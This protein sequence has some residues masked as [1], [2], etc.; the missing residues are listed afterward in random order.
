VGRSASAS[1]GEEQDDEASV[2]V[3]S[4]SDEFSHGWSIPVVNK[5]SLIRAGAVVVEAAVV[6]DAILH[7]LCGAGAAH[8]V[9]R[10]ARVRR[11]GSV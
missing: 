5:A 3:A 2:A 4:S 6:S 1:R 11:Q 10:S 9:R 8:A 7:H